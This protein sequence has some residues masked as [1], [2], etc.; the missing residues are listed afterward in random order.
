MTYKHVRRHSETTYIQ[1]ITSLP[2]NSVQHVITHG[3]SQ[4]LCTTKVNAKLGRNHRRRSLRVFC[5]LV[6]VWKTNML[7]TSVVANLPSQ[8]LYLLVRRSALHTHVHIDIDRQMCKNMGPL[9]Q[10]FLSKALAIVCILLSSLH[11]RIAMYKYV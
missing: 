9:L 7:P 4:A 11:C 1:K 10:T 8:H 5:K 3:H 6:K 2:C